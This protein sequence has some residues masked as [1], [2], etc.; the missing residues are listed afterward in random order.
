MNDAQDT[1]LP[2]ARPVRDGAA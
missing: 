2:V 1:F